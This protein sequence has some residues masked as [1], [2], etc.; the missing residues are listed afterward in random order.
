MITEIRATIVSELKDAKPF[1]NV[2][3]ARSAIAAAR[4]LFSHEEYEMSGNPRDET[5]LV[6]VYP[7][8]DTS[9]CCG[10]LTA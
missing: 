4:Q 5:I 8:Q 1:E 3:A 10:F 9:P 7:V 2:D 6:L